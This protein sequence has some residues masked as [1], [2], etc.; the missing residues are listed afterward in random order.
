MTG[1]RGADSQSLGFGF[2]VV[3]DVFERLI[4]EGKTALGLITN[5]AP[6]RVL[7][8]E[9]G[10][11]VKLFPSCLDVVASE[12]ER[13]E[14]DFEIYRGGELGFVVFLHGRTLCCGQATRFRRKAKY[15]HATTVA[16]RGAVRVE[17]VKQVSVATDDADAP[18]T[19]IATFQ[20]ARFCDSTMG[21]V[22]IDTSRIHVSV[23]ASF[24]TKLGIRS[25]L[26]LVNL[27]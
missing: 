8:N 27:R 11:V 2:Q 17:L 19:P 26:V 4:D 23:S 25:G 5:R 10:D 15:T 6:K 24:E 1:E 14:R 21:K 22:V 18:H 16:S 9:R 20:N 13:R 7:R 3:D 12:V